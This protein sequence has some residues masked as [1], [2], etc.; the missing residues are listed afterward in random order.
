[1]TR[2]GRSPWTDQFPKSR[3]PAHPRQRGTFATDVVI[4]GGGLTGCATAYALAAAG[5]KVALGEA[6]SIGCGASGSTGGWISEDP[7]VPFVD[8]EKTHGL[9]GAQHVFH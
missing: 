9:R 2:Y 7:G 3:V 1:M 4:I 6:A 8:L 5:V